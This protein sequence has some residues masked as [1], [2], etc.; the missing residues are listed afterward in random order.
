MDIEMS[1]LN[2]K[3]DNNRIIGQEISL[4]DSQGKLLGKILVNELSNSRCQ[5]KLIF[6]NLPNNL[7]EIL[8]FLEETVNEGVFSF[9]DEID[10]K[11]DSFG[12][13]VLLN[14]GKSFSKIYDVQLMN[15]FDISFKFCDDA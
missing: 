3:P 1:T 8:S 14:G 7:R 9:L 6:D 12:M 11:L 10:Q 2:E 13:G 4:V 5:G 15:R